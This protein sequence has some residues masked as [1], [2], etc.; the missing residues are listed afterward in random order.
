MICDSRILLFGAIQSKF[1]GG[2]VG[3]FETEPPYV[4]LAGLELAV[5]KL[6]SVHRNLPI[7]ASQV[8]V[9][10]LT[11]RNNIPRH[12]SLHAPRVHTLPTPY[13]VL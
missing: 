12:P 5:E 6:A 1:G 7:S 2:M 8:L 10:S 3:W 13:T 4:A 11:E 9:H